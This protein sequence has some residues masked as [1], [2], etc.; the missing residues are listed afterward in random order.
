MMPKRE[1]GKIREIELAFNSPDSA[2]FKKAQKE[3]IIKQLKEYEKLCPLCEGLS[4]LYMFSTC[5]KCNNT[6]KIDWIDQLK[7][8]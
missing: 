7:N 2:I 3:E 1:I 8:T 5:D 6:G 4:K